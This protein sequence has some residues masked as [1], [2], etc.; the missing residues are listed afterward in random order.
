MEPTLAPGDIVETEIVKIVPGGYGLAF[1]ENM[2]LFVALAAVGDKLRVRVREVRGKIAFAEVEE[3]LQPGPNR[4]VPPCPYVGRCGG[5]DFQQ[6]TYAAQLDAKVG[7][8]RDNLQRIGKIDYEPEIWVIGSP[9]E[10]GYRLRAQWHI[11]GSSREI[12]YYE[13]NSRNLIAVAHCPILRPELDAELQRLRSQIE[14][15]K[16]WPDRGSI[17]VASGSDTSISTFSPELDLGNREI[18]ITAGGE[19]YTFTAQAFFQG[20]WYLIDTL[21]QLLYRDRGNVRSPSREASA[22][23]AYRLGD[24]RGMARPRYPTAYRDPRDRE[25]L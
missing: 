1:G 5:C 4:I 12:G 6:M 11:D 25:R 10:F 13:R 14:W 19:N 7:I 8:I 3:I 24:D 15:S 23:V 2:T 21:L 18:T 20:N 9:E 22:A 17:D 16:F